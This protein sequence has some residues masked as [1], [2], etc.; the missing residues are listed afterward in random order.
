MFLHTRP[1]LFSETFTF[2]SY[3]KN[4]QLWLQNSIK[5]GPQTY[6]NWHYFLEAIFLLFWFHFGRLLG[7]LGAPLELQNLEK[8]GRQRKEKAGFYKNCVP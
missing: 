7:R 8:L 6:Q 3:R 4:V 5:N 1:F 2:D